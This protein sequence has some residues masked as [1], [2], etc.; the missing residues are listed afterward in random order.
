MVQVVAVGQN[1]RTIL[2]APVTNELT[3]QNI[4]VFSTSGC[5]RFATF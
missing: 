3:L 4:Q 1:V 2:R 5:F